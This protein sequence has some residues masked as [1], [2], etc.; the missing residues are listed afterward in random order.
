MFG[1]NKHREQDA[2]PETNLAKKWMVGRWPFPFGARPM[3]R[4][5]FVLI[6]GRVRISS[7]ILS[8][9]KSAGVHTT[10]DLPIAQDDDSVVS[11]SC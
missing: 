11:Q 4:G 6:S 1:I 7:K 10:W 8:V 2:L 3:F 5:D 9:S